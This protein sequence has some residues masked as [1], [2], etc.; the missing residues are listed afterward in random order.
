MR[1]NN[2]Y[3]EK[4]NELPVQMRAS[5][6]FIICSFLQKGI[7][8]ITTPIFTRLL[9]AS[10][11]GQYSIFNSWLGIAAVFVSL[12]LSAGVYLQG[13]I[14]FDKERS[15]FSSSLQGLTV[16]SVLLWTAVYLAGR[17]FW[18]GIFSLPTAQMLLMLIMVWTNAVFSF[19]AA[20]QRT[21][22]KYRLL[23]AVTLFVTVLKPTVG[24]VL[25]THAQDK[26][27]ARIIGLAVVE[28][29]AYTGLF[30]KQMLAG[31]TFF[32][33]R[34]WKYALSFNLPLLP[35]Y[36]SQM[37]LSGADRIMIGKMIG[38]REAGLYSLAYSVSMM[39]TLLNTSL[40]GTLN[41]WMYQKIKENNLEKIASVGYL[42]LV[43]I[44]AA[45]ITLIII[46]PELIRIFAPV[47]YYDAV[48][49]VPPVAMSVFFIFS[50]DLFAK[51]AFYYEKTL[52]VM[53]ASV[54][55]AAVNLALNW[56]FIRR[57][58]YL[59]A[60]YTTLVC[61]ILY[62]AGHYLF[63]EKVCRRYCDGKQP[64]KRVMVCAIGMAFMAAGFL[65]MCLY[66]CVWG[67]YF[68]VVFGAAA[69]FLSRKKMIRLYQAV[70]KG[71][72]E[73]SYRSW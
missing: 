51:F 22:Y 53:I 59:A 52:F 10:E 49:I 7:S 43:A 63:M 39:M 67:R 26:V 14:K 11:Y 46:A 61:Y 6:W 44:A 68:L 70:L 41:P 42:S 15:V 5:F 13:L 16:A 27:T 50:Y 8:V 73:K 29:L 12:N 18:N 57:F 28:L 35:H 56:I 32:S 47:E 36:L 72:S 66:G 71:E 21:Y 48:W 23:I 31:R 3:I 45:N 9:S 69:V 58:G 37:V 2:S 17:D 62:A 38:D 1:L 20:E 24:I 54:F 55:G 64:Y 19:W 25:V 60:G 30:F 33:W 34:F 40:L 65:C 4:Y